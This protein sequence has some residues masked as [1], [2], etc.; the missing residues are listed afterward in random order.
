MALFVQSFQE[1]TLTIAAP[2]SPADR[3]KTEAKLR[4]EWGSRR[5]SGGKGAHSCRG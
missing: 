1:R 5:H 4:H 2:G 3:V